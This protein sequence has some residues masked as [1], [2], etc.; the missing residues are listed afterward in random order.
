MERSSFPVGG[1]SFLMEVP[2]FL[3]GNRSFLPRPARFPPW[4]GRGA[5]EGSSLASVL[6]R[7]GARRGRIESPG[8]GL[9]RGW[10]VRAWCMGRPPCA[11][12]RNGTKNPRAAKNRAGVFR[13]G[14]PRGLPPCGA[15][16]RV[17]PFVTAISS[18]RPPLFIN[19]DAIMHE[20]LAGALL[21]QL[22]RGGGDVPHRLERRTIESLDLGDGDA[23]GEPSPPAHGRWMETRPHCR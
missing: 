13:G 1:S 15:G 7:R 3:V 22:P 6:R 18:W 17:R 21:Y 8:T 12:R 5:T 2:S 20:M 19:Q 10:A 9:R 11:V 14:R 23:R 16:W 4:G